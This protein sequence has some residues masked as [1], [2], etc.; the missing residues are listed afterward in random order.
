MHMGP[1]DVLHHVFFGG[2]RRCVFTHE[3]SRAVRATES[4]VKA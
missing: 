3:P 2:R 4:G 1:Y